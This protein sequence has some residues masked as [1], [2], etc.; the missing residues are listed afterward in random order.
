[1]VSLL[2]DNNK[3]TCYF[4]NSPGPKGTRVKQALIKNI[5]N[6]NKVILFAALARS[7]LWGEPDR[8]FV[9][10]LISCVYDITNNL[11]VVHGLHKK[12]CERNVSQAIITFKIK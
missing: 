3:N 8:L 12:K 10:V 9:Y 2:L 5:Y 6:I 4:T 7:P 11:P 1:M